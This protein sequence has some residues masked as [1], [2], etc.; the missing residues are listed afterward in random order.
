[1][2]A[3]AMNMPAAAS[4]LRIFVIAGIRLYREGLAEILGRLPD[5][6]EVDTAEDGRDGVARVGVFRP[7]IVLLDMSLADSLETV[8]VLAHGTPPTRVV[9]LA[10]P[11]TEGHVLACAKAG[12]V[13]YV[14]REGSVHD[15]VTTLRHVAKGEA[16]CAPHIAA[17]LFRQVALLSDRAAPERPPARLT[18]RERQIVDLIALGLANQEIARRLGIELCTVKNH[19]HNI[20]E[21]LNVRRRSEVAAFT[22]SWA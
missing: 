2:R 13:G 8:R 22:H 9:A 17:S 14:P 10:V 21:K 6:A 18:E 5:V 19:V 4:P 7:H 3:Q 20:L 16:V 12:V 11:E 15:L 1:M